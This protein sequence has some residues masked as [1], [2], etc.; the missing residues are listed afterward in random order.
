[1]IT[2]IGDQYQTIKRHDHKQRAAFNSQMFEHAD[3]WIKTNNQA[4]PIRFV[5][6]LQISYLFTE[7]IVESICSRLKVVYQ[8]NRKKMSH[9]TLKRLIQVMMM[10]PDEGS[11]RDKVVEYVAAKYYEKYGDTII[12]DKCYKKGKRKT[13]RSTVLDRHYKG[14][15]SVFVSSQFVL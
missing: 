4:I 1:M 6:N 10:L 13:D 8:D 11:I 5:W 9:R 7:T 12:R 14:K 3:A 2:E 15:R